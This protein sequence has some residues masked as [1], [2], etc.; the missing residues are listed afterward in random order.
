MKWIRSKGSQDRIEFK[1]LQSKIRKMVSKKKNKSWEKIC[2]TVKSY[3]G[4]K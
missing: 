1:R 4:G 3:L 2:L